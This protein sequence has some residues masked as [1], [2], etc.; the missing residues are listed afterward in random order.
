MLLPALRVA[1]EGQAIAE[2]ALVA[3][4]LFVPPEFHSKPFPA[5]LALPTPLRKP[6]NPTLC[7]IQ[8]CLAL[9]SVLMA[10]IN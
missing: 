4:L 8:R 6:G 1:G 3:L 9:S 10:P 7:A 5:P 2:T